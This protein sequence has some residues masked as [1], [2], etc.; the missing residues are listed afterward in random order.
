MHYYYYK[1]CKI[2]NKDSRR[3]PVTLFLDFSEKLSL[4]IRNLKRKI[5]SQLQIRIIY[6]K[7]N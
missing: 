7:I 6:Q 3:R 2:W 4:Y 5:K 1:L